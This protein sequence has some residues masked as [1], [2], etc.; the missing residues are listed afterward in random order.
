MDNF[1]NVNENRFKNDVID[2]YNSFSIK[3]L[4]FDIL[5]HDLNNTL[6][7]AQG[8]TQILT[9]RLKVDGDKHLSEMINKNIIK[10]HLIL[11]NVID[12]LKNINF[13][14][15]KLKQINL[16]EIIQ[17][18]IESSELQNENIMVENQLFSKIFVNGNKILGNLFVNL[19]NNV[20]NHAKEGKKIRLQSVELEKYWQ[21]K[22]IDFGKGISQKAKN[23]VLN[24]TSQRK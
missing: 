21:I 5:K 18:A 1:D 12:F 9:E 13:D 6:I 20:V 22:I 16:Y 3:E 14:N 19:F 23:E 17:V 15:L 8:F 11:N 2:K 10:S 4:F 7:T 24:N